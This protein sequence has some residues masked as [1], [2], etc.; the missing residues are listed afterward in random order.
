MLIIRSWPNYLQNYHQL[1]FS[2]EIAVAPGAGLG[3]GKVFAA[4]GQNTTN[5]AGAIFGRD[6]IYY[7]KGDNEVHYYNIGNQTEMLNVVTIPADEQI[8]YLEHAF[9]GVTQYLYQYITNTFI[10]LANKPDG[11]WKLYAYNY[12]QSGT[13]VDIVEPAVEAYSG[14]GVAVNLIYRHP[15]TKLTY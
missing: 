3:D 2:A 15:N 12:D 7:S 5:V 6:G 11:T 9:D 8:V 1:V 14:R 4:Q 10:V 13:G